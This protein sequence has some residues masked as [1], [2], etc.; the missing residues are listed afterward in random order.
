MNNVLL[1]V[2]HPRLGILPLVVGILAMQHW[3][4]TPI[5]RLHVF[6]AFMWTF[7]FTDAQLMSS[8]C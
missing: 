2:R 5:L 4:K 6:N 7:E 1:G 3:G 8:T